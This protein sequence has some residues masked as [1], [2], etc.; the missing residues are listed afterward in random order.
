MKLS[1]EL[2]ILLLR[3]YFQDKLYIIKKYLKEYILKEKIR[4]NR[5]LTIASIL[6]VKKLNKDI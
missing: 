1:I 3:N 4:V 5:I 2:S 6:L